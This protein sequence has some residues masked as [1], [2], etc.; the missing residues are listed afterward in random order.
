MSGPEFLNG[1]AVVIKTSGA[2]TTIHH[3]TLFPGEDWVFYVESGGRFLPFSAD[4]LER[5]EDDA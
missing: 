4:E 1:E 3:S 2:K 5:A